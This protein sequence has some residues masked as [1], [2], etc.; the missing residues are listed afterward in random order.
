MTLPVPD[1]DDRRFQGL[2]DDAKRLV[3]QRCPEWT[4]HNVHDPGVTLIE[5]FAFMVDQLMYRL[6]RVP[7]RLYVT[8]L[9]LIGVGLLPPAAARAAVTFHLSAPREH[10]LTVPAGTE[11]STQRIDFDEAI[12]FSTVRDLTIVPCALERLATA[13]TRADAVDRS[14]DL[15]SSRAVR[16]FS[17]V[18]DVGDA[19]LVGLTAAVPSH[20]VAL[21][22]DCDLEGVGVVPTNPPLAWEAW[23]GSTWS[24]CEVE[25]DE[26][27]GLNEAGDVLLHVPAS[28]QVA[29]IMRHRAGWLRCR[30]TP[31]V[32]GQTGYDRS[33]MIRGVTAF[34]I[35]GTVESVHAD[36]VRDEAVGL[37]EGVPGQRFT[38]SRP[39]VILGD[40]PFV[41]E[42]AAGD[43]WREWSAVDSFA[44]SGPT[45][46]HVQIDPTTGELRFGPAVREA[47]GSLTLHGAVPPKA[48]P[49]RIPS[50]RTGGGRRGNVSRGALTVLRSS[51]PFVSRV[52]NRRPGTGGIDG[53]S[54]EAAKVRGPLALRTR[55][56]AVTA[57][58][59]EQLA[60]Q[61]ASGIARVRC[62]SSGEGADAGGVRI[63]VIPAAA[64]DGTGR[65]RFEDLVPSEHLLT[66]VTEY[67]DQRRVVGARLVVE[68][69]YYQG[70][71]IVARLT[72]RG[73]TQPERL[74]DDALAALYRY[75]NPLTG[76]PDGHG[77]PFGRPAQA[78][79]VFAVL[80]GL[81]GTEM[82]DEVNLFAADPLTGQ[83]GD[84][85]QRI[86]L[87]RHG[88]V[89]SFEHQV[90]AS[91]AG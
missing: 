18:P 16:C 38:V 85:A 66:R 32:E 2:V 15:L 23:D 5:T 51:I 44:A 22:L 10:P 88:L 77:W 73:R 13:A 43:G 87:D 24:P 40:E 17:E 34:S 45:D 58:D 36:T 25:R 47:D 65:L 39:P 82:V 69:P 27:G 91:A 76:G 42:V 12:I 35:G 53:E 52:E 11:V 75:F 57:E 29:T 59:Y 86:D 9:D 28:H 48:A 74:R 61:A 6:N 71:T 49:L 89:F 67:L 1:L 60:R 83:R 20:V 46:R 64:D 63:L 90:R 50:Y 4:D 30:V 84:P 78:G 21:R 56:R 3:Q 62:V 55:D 79:E 26:T 80:Q 54:V 7:D 37:S 81:P 8:F 70:I 14:D 41:V 68:P 19:L 31:I 33:P 72:A